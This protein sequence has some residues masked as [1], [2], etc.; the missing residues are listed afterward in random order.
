MLS[1]PTTDIIIKNPQCDS[2][3]PQKVTCPISSSHVGQQLSKATTIQPRRGLAINS[4]SQART[5]SVWYYRVDVSV[6]EEDLRA[7]FFSDGESDDS[8][9]GNEDGVL[10]T[11]DVEHYS[12]SRR[13]SDFLQLYEK[14]R[15]VLIA[16]GGSA[17]AMPRFPA[18]ES[19]SPTLVGLVRRAS[20]SEVV[21]EER[22]SK[23]EAVLQWIENHP[24]ARN[25]TTFVEFLGKPPQTKDGY[26]SLKEYVSPDWLSSLQQTTKDMESRRHRY[27]T[28]SSRLK[29]SHSSSTNLS[30]R[31][32][33][34]SRCASAPWEELP[35][36]VQ[37]THSW[38]NRRVSLV[39]RKHATRKQH[40]VAVWFQ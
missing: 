11:T 4:V 9:S 6:Y 13:Y 18:K 3:D 8:S 32:T 24:T 16:A 14:I 2:I 30:N 29:R 12:I 25:S 20:S 28:N 1:S 40:R 17:T 26:V 37:L 23:F 36:A 33:S 21:L 19:I 7:T 38:L 15:A 31:P 27:S 22:R 39:L 35:D 34:L 5:I 10:Q